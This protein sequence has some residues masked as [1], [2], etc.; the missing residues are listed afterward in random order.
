ISAVYHHPGPTGLKIAIAA[1]ISGL[2]FLVI[3]FVLGFHYRREPVARPESPS[4]KQE[5]EEKN[6]TS[7]EKESRV[8]A[9]RKTMQEEVEKPNKKTTAKV[10]GPVAK[11]EESP[12]VWSTLNPP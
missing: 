8:K 6:A 10:E 3:G 5:R 11:V 9:A 12:F 1:A 4:A 7:T 2:L